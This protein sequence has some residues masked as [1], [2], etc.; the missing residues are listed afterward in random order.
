MYRPVKL[1]VGQVH[2]LSSLLLTG[3]TYMYKV[4]YFSKKKKNPLLVP[5]IGV[6]VHLLDLSCMNSMQF[7]VLSPSCSWS[8]HFSDALWITCT[9]SHAAPDVL[10][11]HSLVTSFNYV[12]VHS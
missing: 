8:V 11:F 6:D 5:T 9:L 1:P 2:A 4:L 12:G 7:H 3:G 10:H